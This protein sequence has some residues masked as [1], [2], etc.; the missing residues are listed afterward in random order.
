ME[1]KAEDSGVHKGTMRVNLEMIGVTEV[2]ASVKAM[3]SLR[4]MRVRLEAMGSHMLT[5][6]KAGCI[7]L[8]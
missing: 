2:M 6:S 3:C 1:S 7:G 5:E 8:M 4:S